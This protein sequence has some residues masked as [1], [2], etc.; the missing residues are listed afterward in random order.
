MKTRLVARKSISQNVSS[1]GFERLMDDT[2]SALA[3]AFSNFDALECFG[4]DSRN[5]NGF[6]GSEAAGFDALFGETGLRA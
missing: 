1:A 5:P 2:I 3:E 4:Q 6:S